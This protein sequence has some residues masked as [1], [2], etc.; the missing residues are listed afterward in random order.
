MKKE[1]YALAIVFF[2][3][4]A[5]FAAWA[6][7]IPQLQEHLALSNGQLGESMFCEAIGSLISMP[8]SAALGARFGSAKMTV[9]FSVG[10]CLTLLLIPLA[11]NWFFF[12][13]A[14][15]CF[16]FTLGGQDV[17]MNAQAV[18][19]ERAYQRPIMSSFHGSYS[20]GAMC[21]AGFSALMCNLALSPLH[22]FLIVA[23]ILA[24][25]MLLVGT[26]LTP[27]LPS[28]QKTKAPMFVLPD[29]HVLV[30]STVAFCSF[31]GEG[32]IS[33]WSA[34]YLAHELHSSASIAAAGLSIFCLSMSVCRFAGDIVV[35]RLGPTRVL[36]WG[37]L[38]AG[39]GIA[40]SLIIPI[41]VAVLVAYF[42]VGIGFSCM[43]PVAFSAAGRARHLPTSVAIASVATTGYLGFIIA[44]PIIGVLAD[45]FSLRSALWLTVVL[46][47]AVAVLSKWAIKESAGESACI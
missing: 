16:G 29:R 31:V 11:S 26:A 42:I 34:V 17:S 12:S 8:A 33:D 22:H 47:L 24:P 43:V 41:P 19:V 5:V 45:H 21:G 13:L 39:S 28:E 1:R 36:L 37:G 35:L 27:T 9:L 20:V 10:F 23:A 38:I 25:S 15:F 30:L 2:S 32:A 7:R 6:G 18:H 40:A 4:G 14:L 46:S 44:P 3:L